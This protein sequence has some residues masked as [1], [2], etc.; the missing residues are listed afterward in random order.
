MVIDMNLL[1]LKTIEQLRQFL[2]ST[3][4]LEFASLADIPA[5]YAH[6]VQTIQRFAYESL[7]RKDRSVI[8]RYLERT[9]GYSNAQVKRLVCRALAGEVLQQ[10][11]VA[12]TT[13]YAR[14]FTDQDIALLAQLDR[15]F[16]TLSG[17]ATS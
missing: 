13:A 11:Y 2:D 1:K 6:I 14:R 12:P 4:A 15:A 8:L 7:G 17:A 3:Q 5:C 10:R 16:D 9:S